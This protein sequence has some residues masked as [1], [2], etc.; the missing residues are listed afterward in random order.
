LLR[1]KIGAIGFRGIGRSVLKILG[2]SAVMGAAIWAVDFAVASNVHQNTAG[3]ALRLVAGVPVGLA[4][5]YTISRLVR[6]GELAETKDMLRAVFNR[7][8][9]G[10]GAAQG[11]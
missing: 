7:P 4:V 1:R 11:P 8:Q 2:A 10:D 3:Y 5:F 6:M 9:R